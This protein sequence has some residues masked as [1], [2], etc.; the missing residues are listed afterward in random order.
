MPKQT[1]TNDDAA[2]AA[3][4]SLI[5]D[6]LATYAEIA[7]LMGISRQAVR[8]WNVESTRATRLSRLWRDAIKEQTK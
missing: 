4:Q 8:Q 5:R 7:S 3:A 1:L 2:R 6:G